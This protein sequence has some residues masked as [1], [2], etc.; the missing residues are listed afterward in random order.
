[1]FGPRPAAKSKTK[2]RKPLRPQVVHKC[3]YCKE[4][5]SIVDYKDVAALQRMVSSQA[6]ILSRKRTGHCAFH[7]RAAQQAIKRA[8]Y[9]AL[10]NYVA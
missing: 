1:M 2:P 10:L 5:I 6:K 3:R 9:M 8:R 4:M 7:Q